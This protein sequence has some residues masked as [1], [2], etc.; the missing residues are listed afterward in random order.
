MGLWDTVFGNTKCRNSDRL[1][2]GRYFFANFYMVFKGFY[3]HPDGD[4]QKSF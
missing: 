3:H 4:A 1:F 2:Y